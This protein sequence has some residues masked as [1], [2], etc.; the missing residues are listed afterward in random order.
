MAAHRFTGRSIVRQTPTGRVLLGRRVPGGYRFDTLID[1]LDMPEPDRGVLIAAIT[2]RQHR[3]A[4]TSDRRRSAFYDQRYLTLPALL[5]PE[6][7]E[8]TP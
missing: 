6:G 2:A 8:P 7:E 5:P 1:L 3:L 4:R